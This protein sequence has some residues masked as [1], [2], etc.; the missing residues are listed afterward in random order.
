MITR[1]L[2]TGPLRSIRGQFLMSIKDVPEISEIFAGFDI[3]A[4]E[5]TYT[6]GGGRKTKTAGELVIT[7]G[8]AATR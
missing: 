4:V 8:G 6:A 2:H 7:G 5:T 3:E 1:E